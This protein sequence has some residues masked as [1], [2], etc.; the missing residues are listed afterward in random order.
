MCFYIVQFQ[1]VWSLL[2]VVSTE[3]CHASQSF[4]FSLN[5]FDELF[6]VFASGFFSKN[7]IHKKAEILPLAT[8]LKDHLRSQFNH[9]FAILLSVPRYKRVN[10]YQ[11]MYKIKLSLQNLR[12]LGA[13]LPDLRNR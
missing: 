11:N 8:A 5:V 12:A 4:L 9:V 3:F 10:F 2:V 6:Q 7:T 1:D 13:P